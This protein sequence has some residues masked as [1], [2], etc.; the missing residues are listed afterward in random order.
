MLIRPSTP[1]I[2]W[3]L[4]PTRPLPVPRLAVGESAFTTAAVISLPERADAKAADS[5]S[6]KL[7]ISRIKVLVSEDEGLAREALIT[8][9]SDYLLLGE[10]HFLPAF[11][12]QSAL[13]V[14]EREQLDI[15]AVLTDLDMPEPYAG[16]RLQ[17]ELRHYFAFT[18]PIA[19]MSA[20]SATDQAIQTVLSEDPETKFFPKPIIDIAPLGDWL[21]RAWS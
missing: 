9:L 8:L 18:G 13:A 1:A 4:A 20:R 11:N 15:R 12:L 2:A 19:L 21:R 10:E 16:L 17:H 3:P 5:E 6:E 14:F 7:D